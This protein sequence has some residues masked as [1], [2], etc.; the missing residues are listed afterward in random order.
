MSRINALLFV[1]CLAFSAE[2]AARNYQV[3]LLIFERTGS[4]GDTEERW[5][6]RSNQVLLSNERLNLMAQQAD[7]IG[8]RQGV[9][10]LKNIEGNLIQSGYR[11][12]QSLRWTQRGTIFPNAPVVNVSNQGNA[13]Q[14]YLRVYKTSLIF[15]DVNIGLSDAAGGSFQPLFFINEKRRI[16]FKEVHYF[17]HPKLGVILTVWPV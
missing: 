10:I 9:N 5:D 12:I 14:G 17:D 13:L 3:E 6:P 11:V 16:K 2:A 15:A 1:I 8:L 4:L 7:D